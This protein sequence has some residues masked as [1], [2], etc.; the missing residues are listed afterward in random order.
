[1]AIILFDD[2]L[3][4]RRKTR[5]ERERITAKINTHFGFIENPPV[6]LDTAVPVLIRRP[7][8]FCKNCKC[9]I[10]EK[11]YCSPCSQIAPEKD[12]IFKQL[13]TTIKNFFKQ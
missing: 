13:F 10:S 6:F 7:Y 1:M 2:N 12:S 3:P 11:E 8:L 4:K 9:A 5:A